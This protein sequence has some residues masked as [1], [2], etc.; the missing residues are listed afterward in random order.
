MRLNRRSL[1]RRTSLDKPLRTFRPARRSRQFAQHR[2]HHAGS[3]SMP[4]LL[5]QFHAL[6]DCSARRNAIQVQQLK[7][8]QP[9]RNQIFSIEFRIGPLEKRLQPLIEFDLPSQHTQHQCG[10]QMPVRR[11]QCRHSLAAQQI[12]GVPRSALYRHEHRESSLARCRNRGHRRQLD[13][14]S[15]CAPAANCIPRKNSATASRFLP[16]SCTSTN[17]IHVFPA[18]ATNNR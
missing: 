9:Q 4:R 12:V 5:G 8:A 11:R 18:H 3:K 6:I 13:R 14:A 2:V 15:K 1:C 16:S 10:C 17:S 7:R